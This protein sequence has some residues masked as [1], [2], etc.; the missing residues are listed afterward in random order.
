MSCKDIVVIG[1]G[2]AG[3]MA[4]IRAGQLKQKV[5]LLEKTSGLGNKLLLTGKG[6]CNLTNLCELDDFIKRF[7]NNGQFLRDAFKVFFNQELVDFFQKRGLRMKAE[8]QLRVFPDSD[9]SDNILGVLKKELLSNKVKVIYNSQVEEVVLKDNVIDKLKLEDKTTISCDAAVLATGGVSYA[10]TGSTGEG[11][12]IAEKLGH[13]LVKLRPGLI[14]LVTKEKYPKLLE[15]LTLR[16]IRLIFSDG[17]KKITSEIGELLFTDFGISGPLV[18]TLSGKIVDWLEAGK[19]VYV[20]ID[21]KPAL[22]S[23]KV[24]ARILREI[25][26][27]PKKTMKNML[28]DLLP[29][30]LVDVFLEMSGIQP[31]KIVSYITQEERKRSV[32]LLKALRFNISKSRP[33]NMAM[34]TRG[35]VSLKDISPR[36]MESRIVKN[37]YFAGEIMDID[38]DTGG[39]N[40]QAAFSTGYLAGQSAS[41]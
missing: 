1:G 11:L 28:K 12:K 24:E 22:S 17:K 30:R 25:K 7:S 6:R 13:R 15:G 3:M 26:A 40:L 14:A 4:A 38:A 31:D 37:L 27:K 10:S 34:I 23:E 39:F 2:P 8:R 5:T 29:V 9:R 20:D 35:G 41:K 33:M 21:L 36:T 32:S 19:E 16:N 18:L